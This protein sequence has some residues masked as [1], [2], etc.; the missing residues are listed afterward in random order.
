MYWALV[1]LLVSLVA[2]AFAL[3]TPPALTGSVALLVACVFMAL[4]SVSLI[5][6]ALTR[7]R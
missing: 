7:L 3:W 4:A 2:A 1:Y 5:G 6:A